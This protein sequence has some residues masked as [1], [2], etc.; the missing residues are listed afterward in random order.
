MWWP[1][2]G[3]EKRASNPYSDALT[4]A[5]I[6]QSEG[7]DVPR[8]QA[9]AT[10]AVEAAMGLYARAFASAKVTGTDVLKPHV[11]AY[12]ARELVRRGE[13]LHMLEVG[14]SGIVLIPASSWETYGDHNPESWRYQLEVSGPTTTM[15]KW[16]DG[17]AVV[18]CR[19]S[20]SPLRPWEGEGP[21]EVGGLTSEMLSSLETRLGEEAATPALNLIPSPSAGEETDPMREALRNAKEGLAMVPTMMAGGWTGDRASQ[22][23][24]EWAVA[25]V[26]ANPPDTL[27]ALRSEVGQ[28]VAVACGIPSDLI[29]SGSDSAGQREAYRRWLHSS[30]KPLGVLVASE[31]SEKLESEVAF[32]FEALGAGD[33]TGR[34]RSAKQL[35]EAGWSKEDAGRIAGLDS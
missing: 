26:G 28:A 30:V 7:I 1:F 34:T 24:R 18:H 31:M 5:L 3:R 10:A 23:L 27:R 35:V 22:P 29:M 20:V 12:I 33:L 16:V 4:L 17:G 8:S 11:L 13:S 25:R 14:R 19:W 15:T 2:K 21:L 9:E 32:N 6:R